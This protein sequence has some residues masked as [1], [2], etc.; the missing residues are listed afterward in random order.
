MKGLVMICIA[1]CAASVS[2]R[3]VVLSAEAVFHTDKWC[4]DHHLSEGPSGCIQYEGCC[5]DGRIGKCHS[6]DAHSDEWC[7]T[8]GGSDAKTCVGYAGCT[9]SYPEGPD[10]LGTCVSNADPRPEDIEDSITCTEMLSR[11]DAC[12]QEGRT[13]CDDPP[14]C[15]D[16]GEYIDEQID[17]DGFV[18][19]VS[20]EGHLIPDTKKKEAAF[21]T[22]HINCDKE[23]KKHRGMQCPNAVTLATGNGEVMINDHPDVGNCDMTC[24]TDKDCD[25]NEWCCYNGCGYSCQEPILPKADCEHL[26]LEPSEQASVLDIV[27][28]GTKVTISCAEGYGGS[29]DVN[30]ECKHGSW[31]EFDLDCKKNCEEYHFTD[32]RKRDYEI[33]G[34]ALIHDSKRKVSCQKGYGAVAGSP[35]A[36]RFYKETLR[37]INGAWEER[38]L[39]CSSCF[40]APLEGPNGFWT[41][42]V[43][44]WQVYDHDGNPDTPD[45]RALRDVGTV[46]GGPTSFDC[47]YFAS[48][49][50]KCAEF[51][52]AQKNCRISCR[53]CEQALMTFKVKAVTDSKDDFFGHATRHPEKWLK[54]KLRFLNVFRNWVT[55]SKMIKVAKRVKKDEDVY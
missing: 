21:K 27:E 42:R 50:L 14:E 13:D 9:M 43:T 37:C 49:P 1:L 19:C 22:S 8:Y 16:E 29:D 12:A 48:R 25:D 34:N 44:E 7:T 4:Q 18:W 31:N 15:D 54:K 20:E 24:N 23:R 11:V 39:Q 52:D 28:H 26:I 45:K 10:E 17:I 35:D 41:G 30:I 46:R 47:I 32:S 36:M 55:E 6:C 33:A 40:D 3:V 51:V 38:T 5:Y 2:A 53:T